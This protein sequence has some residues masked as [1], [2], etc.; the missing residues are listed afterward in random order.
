LAAFD[1][2][3]TAADWLDDSRCVASPSA[4]YQR[5][6]AGW[7]TE[8]AIV[9]PTGDY[10]SRILSAF[11]ESKT[12]PE[13]LTDE[14]CVVE[15]IVLVSRINRGWDHEKAITTPPDGTRKGRP[16][17]NAKL[18]EAWGESK[19]IREWLEDDRCTYKKRQQIWSRINK[20]GWTP[21]RAM[22]ELPTPGRPRKPSLA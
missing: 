7:E 22:T 3:K 15:K 16:A 1:E 4:F 19:T 8:R 5:I 6:A 12:W 21:E 18:I 2:N 11:G 20:S 13:W 17:P 14:R 9:T 10:S